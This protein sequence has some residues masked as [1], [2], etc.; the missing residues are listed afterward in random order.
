MKTGY[1]SIDKT[2]LQG[3]PEEKL[4]PEIIPA[5]MLAAFMKINGEHLD[6]IA[7]EADGKTY[8]KNDLKDDAIKFAGLLLKEGIK[9]GDKIAVVTPNSYE[10]IVAIF[11][12]NAIGVAVVIMKPI[13]ESDVKYFYEELDIHKPKMVLFYDNSAAWMSAVRSYAQYIQVH[14]ATKPI[15]GYT[16]QYFGFKNAIDKV[17]F[18]LEEVMKE[19]EKHSISKD[20]KPML[21][22]KTSGSASKPKTLPF[23]NRAI[24]A[25]LIYAANSTGT[26]TRDE[27]VKK[28]LCQASY[29]HGY[30]FMPLFVNI[31]G[32]NPVILA[33]ATPK[34]VANYYK[35]KPS[36][37]YGSPLTLRQFME[38]TPK[39][40]DIS[41]LTAFFCAGAA[42][43]EK[44][45]EE[46]IKYFRD[47]GCEAEI[48]NNYGISEGMCIG[49]V[50][51]HVAHIP[52]TAGKFYIGPEWL[53][54]DENG[55]EV[56][57]GE[58]GEAIVSAASLCQGYFG[59]EELTKKCFIK[60]DG[61]TFFKTGD[62]LSLSEDGYVRFIGRERRF[63]IAV[64]IFEKV[65]CETVEEAIS[66]L[67]GVYQNA[68]VVTPD[69]TSCKAFI[70]LKPNTTA[71]EQ[72]IQSELKKLLQAYEMPREIVFLDKIPMM[73]SGKVNYKLLKTM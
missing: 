10:G 47:H 23:S 64:G 39:D 61:K 54:V 30:G 46:G 45:Y 14:L 72:S 41:S 31:M 26:D 68:V 59:D 57:Y 18:S 40:A 7:V 37:I 25:S 67:N 44:D 11:G 9:A 36:Y 56:K 49:T 13:D 22:L 21:Y 8:T 38:S 28:V 4:H 17:E 63:F 66:S 71:T 16:R 1:P 69:E 70:V 60:R 62:F 34:D 12:A 29:Y 42:L 58:V 5:S 20:D 15:D 43:H 53:I 51:D 3:I 35:L 2:H 6:E 55:D 50:N 32:G 19:I 33:G 52:G 73:D 24:F 48:R 27:T 65:N